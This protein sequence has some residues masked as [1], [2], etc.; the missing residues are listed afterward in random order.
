MSTNPLPCDLGAVWVFE[1]G[2]EAPR[3]RRDDEATVSGTEPDQDIFLIR[4]VIGVSAASEQ[5]ST[6]R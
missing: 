3:P 5:T 6:A 2:A 4:P 1:E